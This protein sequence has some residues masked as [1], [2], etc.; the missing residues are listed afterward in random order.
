MAT[1]QDDMLHKYQEI[2]LPASHTEQ[3]RPT[4]TN[5]WE[6][7]KI[8][9]LTTFS[10]CMNGRPSSDSVCLPTLSNQLKPPHC[11]RKWITALCV[12]KFLI[13]PSPG[14]TTGRLLIRYFER[15]SKTVSKESSSL[16]G[17]NGAHRNEPAMSATYRNQMI[18]LSAVIV[19]MNAVLIESCSQFRT[20]HTKSFEKEYCEMSTAKLVPWDMTKCIKKEYYPAFTQTFV[21]L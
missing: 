5:T 13:C 12:M 18:H 19:R 3:Q 21:C 2:E 7:K 9:T 10:G 11:D 17:K 14:S 8:H 1:C 6:K 16:T 20:L 15:R 4:H